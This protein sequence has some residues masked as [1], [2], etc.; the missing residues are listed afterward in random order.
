MSYTFEWDQKY[1]VHVKEIDGQHKELIKLISKL[2]ISINQRK[3]NEE[4]G[5]LLDELIKYASI[6]FSTE[7]KYFKK[8]SYEY[9]VEHIKE[10]HNFTRK[11][12]DLQKKYLNKEIEI[13]FE[14]IDFL[15]DWLIQHLITADQ[16]YVKCFAKND[17]N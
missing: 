8:F 4:L 5:G 1:S 9:T 13:S 11:I 3:V 6:H 12:T 15:E 17:L 7:E 14:L 16:K 10:H 2:Y